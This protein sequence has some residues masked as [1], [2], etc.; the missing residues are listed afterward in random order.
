MTA[1]SDPVATAEEERHVRLK[2]R[3]VTTYCGQQNVT[4]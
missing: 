1:L 4:S 2:R 3:K